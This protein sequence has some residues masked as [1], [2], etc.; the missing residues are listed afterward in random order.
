MKE[1]L[2]SILIST[3]GQVDYTK[4]CLRSLEAT[5]PKEIQ[6]EILVIDDCSDDETPE[7]LKKLDPKIR[8]FYNQERKGFAINNNLLASRARGKFLCF[9]N[10]DVF[11]KENWLEPML[12]AFQ[13]FENAGIVGNVQRLADQ[14]NYDHMG[15]VFSP[16]GNPRHFGQSFRY[17]PFKGQVKKWSAVTAACCLIRRDYFLEIGGFDEIFLNG[18]EDVDLCLRIAMDGKD[19]LVAHDSVVEHVKSASSGR[20]RFNEKNFK[21]LNQRWGEKI[22]KNQSFTDQ[23]LH[24]WTYFYR[25][26]VKPWS[27]NFSKWI[28]SAFI[29]SRLKKLG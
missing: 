27:I 22:R 7:F 21:I 4:R 28:Q 25:G 20:K 26:L 18:C 6:S 17:R 2:V 16:E 19:C 12:A 9:L 5:F 24:A 8:T 10:N 13:D 14:A 29:L 11:L 3:Y 15:V 1:P 23:H